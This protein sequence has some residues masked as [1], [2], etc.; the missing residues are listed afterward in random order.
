MTKLFCLRA[1][2]GHVGNTE[3][4]LF[5]Q[6]YQLGMYGP[7]YVWMLVGGYKPR[8][9]AVEDTRCSVDQL[10]QATEG[11]FAVDNLNSIIG[12]KRAVSGL[13]SRG[14]SSGT[15]GWVGHVV[16]LGTEGWVGCAWV[17]GS[18]TEGWVGR[19]E[20]CRAEASLGLCEATD[21]Q[22]NPLLLLTHEQELDNAQRI[23]CVFAKEDVR[24]KQLLSSG[25]A[26]AEQCGTELKWTNHVTACSRRLSACSTLSASPSS[27]LRCCRDLCCL[28]AD[29]GGVPGGVRRAQRDGAAQPV[30]AADVRHG[31]DGRADAEAGDAAHRPESP[32]VCRGRGDAGQAPCAANRGSWFL[33]VNSSSSCDAFHP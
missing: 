23:T 9:W 16:G 20:R 12:S 2:L 13:V 33:C 3:T 17:V 25:N 11:Y 27:H 1:S 7:R 8:W 24:G 14:Q 30:R 22:L 32:G 21:S 5:S 28:G 26:D 29:D 15:E 19:L 6:A 31:V 18:G 4:L 10:T